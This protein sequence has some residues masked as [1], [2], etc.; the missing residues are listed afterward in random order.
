MHFGSFFDLVATEVAGTL[1]HLEPTKSALA[2]EA[3][4]DGDNCISEEENFVMCDKLIE[5]FG[6]VF[7]FSWIGY[8]CSQSDIYRY[9]LLQKLELSKR[10]VFVVHLRLEHTD[11]DA[12]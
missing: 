10:I 3:D 12:P 7:T 9:L 1:K 5:S 2:G 6:H 11:V 8:D 4:T